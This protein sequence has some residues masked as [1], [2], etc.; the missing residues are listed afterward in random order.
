MYDIS[1]IR[2]CYVSLALDG[3]KIG[4]L[5]L[6]RDFGIRFRFHCCFVFA[7]PMSVAVLF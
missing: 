5:L 3:A 4:R 1:A 6:N 7:L 2:S